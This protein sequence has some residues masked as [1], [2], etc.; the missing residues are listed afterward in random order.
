MKP[1]EQIKKVGLDRGADVAGI[2]SVKDINPYP[3]PGYRPGDLLPGAKSVVT[4]ASRWTPRGVWQ[5][6]NYSL[7]VQNRSFGERERLH[8]SLGVAHFIEKNYGYY[9][10]TFEGPF[11]S[12]KLPAELSG[13]GTRS[14]AGGIILNRELGPINIATVITTMPLKADRPLEE[15]VCPDPSC[16]TMWERKETTPCLQKC[17][18]CLSGELENGSIKWMRFDKQ[19]CT[20]RAQTLSIGGFQRTLL[21]AIDEPDREKR[22]MMLLGGFFSRNV[23]QIAKG[24]TVG[25]CGECL[26]PC[27]IVIRARRLEPKISVEELTQD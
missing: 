22:K 27:P 10:L 9:A 23:I 17:P 14:L 13:L 26:R 25:Q 15:P 18:E 1:E 11:M 20:T 21:E 19:M 5:S 24:A 3:P 12:V 8:A 6:P 16:V 4:F 2:A 7:H